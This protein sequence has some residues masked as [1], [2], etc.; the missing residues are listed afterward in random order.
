MNAHTELLEKLSEFWP[1]G[2]SEEARLKKSLRNYRKGKGL[3]LTFDV[4]KYLDDN[5]KYE[6]VK[7]E[8]PRILNSKDLILFD[9]WSETPYYVGL[10]HVYISDT[11]QSFT[12]AFIKTFDEFIDYLKSM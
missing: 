3:S 2:M 12:L 9:K 8:R 1:E 6:F 4:F 7:L 5:E 11:S 10:S